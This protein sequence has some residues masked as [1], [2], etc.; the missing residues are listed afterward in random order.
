MCAS[1][2]A[3]RVDAAAELVL[4]RPEVA[5]LPAHVA[6]GPPRVEGAV[7]G[8]LGV[9]EPGQ[10]GP[11]ASAVA[12]DEVVVAAVLGDSRPDRREL[13]RDLPVAL[14][15]P[16]VSTPRVGSERPRERVLVSES[17]SPGGVRQVNSATSLQLR[18]TVDLP[19][20]CGKR[21]PP[22]EL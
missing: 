22:R 18:T 4:A 17:T 5:R 6:L 21:K 11:A 14:D 12:V 2:H 10:A 20:L 9:L 19:A 1:T 13:P 3:A 16:P 15:R 7:A 8:R